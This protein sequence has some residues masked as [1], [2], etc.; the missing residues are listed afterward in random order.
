MI[1]QEILRGALWLL[2]WLVGTAA[3]LCGV[4]VGMMCVDFWLQERRYRKRN[5]YA[6]KGES[7]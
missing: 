3:A 4:L 1:D 7:P 2:V 6:S 5:K